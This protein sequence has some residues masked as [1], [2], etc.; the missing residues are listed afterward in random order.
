MLK[1]GY[2]HSS[3]MTLKLAVSQVWVDG[4][5]F[6][7]D[8]TNSEQLNNFP[9]IIGWVQSKNGFGLLGH[10]TQNLLYLRN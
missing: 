7:H 5:N 8:D 3:H 9:I 1:H 10:G 2:G 6:L 4:V